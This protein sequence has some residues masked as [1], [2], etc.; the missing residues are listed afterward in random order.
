MAQLSV[1]KGTTG[2]GVYLDDTRITQNKV[3]GLISPVQTWKVDYDDVLDAIPIDVI[4]DYLG[5]RDNIP[6]E[7]FESG[8]I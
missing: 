2:T 5:K 3:Y 6:M 1:C 8:E 7:Y 4:K